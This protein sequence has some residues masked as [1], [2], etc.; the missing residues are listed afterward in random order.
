M[1]DFDFDL[2]VIGG[3]S[4]GVRAARIAATHGARVGIA[5]EY[6]YGGTCVIRGCVPKKLMVYAS[7][8]SEEFEDAAGFG[9]QVGER[10]FDWERLIDAKDREIARLEAIYR[11]NLERSGVELFDTRAV[12]EDA[13]TVHLLTDG[14][15]IRAERILIAV[16]ATPN[17]DAGLPGGEHVIT[18][19][20]VF[21][22]AD[23]PKRIVVAGGGYIAVEF[24]GIFAGLGAETTLIYRGEEIL[25]GF[26][27]D[28]RAVL[29][30]EME[31]KGIRVLCGDVFSSIEKTGEGLV[32][33]TRKGETLVADKIMFA[34]GRRPNTAGLG[35]DKA[36]VELASSGA[37]LVNEAS[38][39]NVPSIYAV[40]DVTDRVNLTPVAIREGHAFADS[41]FGGKEW[42]A[43][44]SMIPTA[45][46]SQPE[47]GTVGLTQAEALERYGAVDVYKA[48][49]RPMKHTLSGRDEKMLM[50]V[51]VRPETDRVLGVHLLGHDAGELVQVLGI[52]LR[53]G[54]TKADFDATMAVHPTAA[55]E[56]VTMR[57]PTERLRA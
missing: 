25:R 49:F 14:R 45:V 4:G 46:F 1:S 20:E 38:Q 3:G 37:I 43:D 16:G 31:K 12:L 27:D 17:V 35:L 52:A 40:G 34:I 50:K 36:G 56:L 18:S 11:R 13:H 57:E 42:S 54:A 5:E 51:L 55:E 24:A 39:T 30:E 7:R 15:R 33:H 21:H 44:H 29:H 10:R 41:V 19:N 26:D 6:R 48:H 23:L 9:W 53:M 32:G 8:F 47:I 2:F 28:L 22:L